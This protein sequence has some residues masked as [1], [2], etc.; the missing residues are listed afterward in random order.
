MFS[1]EKNSSDGSSV[2]LYAESYRG[3]KVYAK[4]GVE[5]SALNG[6]AM[7]RIINSKSINFLSSP[8]YRRILA[9][10]LPYG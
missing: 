7:V 3:V 5:R 10:R 6:H 2:K 8:I 1:S 9:E 4:V